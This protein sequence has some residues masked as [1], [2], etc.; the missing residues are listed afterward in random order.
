M[1]DQSRE[2]QATGGS[3][4]VPRWTW[5][6]HLGIR[7][8][9][10]L[11]M[12]HWSPILCDVLLFYKPSLGTVGSLRE[13]QEEQGLQERG[14]LAPQGVG[15]EGCTL[16]LGCSGCRDD[17]FDQGAGRLH[18]RKGRRSLQARHLQILSSSFCRVFFQFTMLSASICFSKFRVRQNLLMLFSSQARVI[19]SGAWLT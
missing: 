11:G 9:V 1:G 2:H 10:Q 5:C 7:P 19:S 14:L 18:W 15:R 17:N 13:H 3:I 12:R 4:R 6:H 16:A 8:L